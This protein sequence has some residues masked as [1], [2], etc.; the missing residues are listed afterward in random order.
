VKA[1]KGKSAVSLDAR[2]PKLRKRVRTAKM[3]A[4]SRDDLDR[5]AAIDPHAKVTIAKRANGHVRVHLVT[6]TD[7]SR[8]RA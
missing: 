1:S 4:M 3:P 2:K 7:P 5:I 8:K 6:Y